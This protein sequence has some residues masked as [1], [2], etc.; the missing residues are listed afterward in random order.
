MIMFEE[1]RFICKT[2]FD[3]NKIKDIMRA[4]N[5]GDKDYMK[6]K[7]TFNGGGLVLL[8]TAFS[9]M[10]RNMTGDLRVNT[11]ITLL[12]AAVGTY[13]LYFGMKKMDI[14]D[15]DELEK[16]YAESLGKVYKYYLG[17]NTL[18]VMIEVESKAENAG[19]EITEGFDLSIPYDQV[20]YTREDALNFFCFID[21]KNCFIL[22]K[23]E[24]NKE[25]FKQLKNCLQKDIKCPS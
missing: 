25:N 15:L 9:M 10:A 5:Y 4:K 7:I 18:D 20:V 16:N 17:E 3:I 13:L 21:E 2:V 1:D 23:K 22:D 14:K 12:L 19:A 11:L 8:L 6:K 24:I